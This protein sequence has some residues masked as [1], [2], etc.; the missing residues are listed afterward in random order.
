MR[1]DVVGCAIPRFW[2]ARLDFME[3]G[4]RKRKPPT[5]ALLDGALPLIHNCASS[6]YV[7]S[8]AQSTLIP[9]L[10]ND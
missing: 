3:K 10:S 4:K 9:A 7:D 2:D 6:N 1:Y 8:M 5:R